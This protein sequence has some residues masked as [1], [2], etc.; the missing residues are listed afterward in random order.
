MSDRRLTLVLVVITATVLV[1]ASPRAMRNN[2][3]RGGFYVFTTEFLTDIPKRLAG[4]GRFRFILQPTVAMLLGARDGIADARAGQPP[5][6]LAM[7][8]GSS[9]RR[10]LAASALAA[11]ANLVLMGILL[12]AV[13]QR[14]ILGVAYPGAALL[15]RTR[16]HRRPVFPGAGPGEPREPRA[17]AWMTGR[18]RR[19]SKSR[20]D[21]MRMAFA[22]LL[23]AVPTVGPQVQP[24]SDLAVHNEK[25]P[26]I[27]LRYVDWHWHARPLR[28][29]GKGGR[30]DSGGPAQLGP[31][32]APQLH[33][34]DLPGKEDHGEQLRLR[35]LAQHGRQGDDVRA[36]EDRHAEGPGAQRLR[37]ASGG[38]GVWKG[39]ANFETVP[40]TVDR[41]SVSLAEDAGK[42]NVT[43]R[44]GNRRAV[45]TFT[46]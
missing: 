14:V 13:F 6:L 33:A 26:S 34:F 23:L 21:S 7:L 41:F 11:I 16:P 38:P 42:V 45:V 32:P 36:S 22:A 44:Y 46:R 4:P 27:E 10:A 17:P 1:L 37:A 15:V 43:I 39:P 28:R 24:A 3:T 2:L 18:R 12:D 20:G 29:D 35:P 25:L 30:Q 8:T 40:D 5:Y 19:N 31:L 9:S